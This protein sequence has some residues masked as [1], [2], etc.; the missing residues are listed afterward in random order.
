VHAPDQSDSMDTRIVSR[1]AAAG[2]V[3][4]VFLGIHATT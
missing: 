4:Y 3:A 2:G 1:V